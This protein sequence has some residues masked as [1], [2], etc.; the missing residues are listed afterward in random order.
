MNSDFCVA[1]HAFVYLN[2]HGGKTCSSKELATNIC[3]NPARVR[4]I[5]A[6]FK[7][8][9]FITTIESGPN[10][11]YQFSGDPDK[12]TLSDIASIMKIDFVEPGWR[13]GDTDMDC[14]ISSGMGNLMDGIFSD[15]NKDCYSKLSDISVSDIERRIFGTTKNQKANHESS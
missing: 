14:L 11:G 3:T 5:L 13:S 1:V 2:H 8:C 15:L 4:K 7:D 6:M 10:S 12:I 9:T